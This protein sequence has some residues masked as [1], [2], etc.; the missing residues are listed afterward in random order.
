MSVHYREAVLQDEEDLFILA[1]RLATSYTLNRVDFS[2]AFQH[3]LANSNADIIVAE[4]ESKL[5]GY[6]LA[7]HHT[8]FY[9]NG[10]VSWVEELFVLEEYRRMNIGKKLMDIVEEKAL[11]RGSRLVAL[12]TRRAGDFYK[13][14]G[15]E[16]SA[17]Y[18]KKT[19]TDHRVDS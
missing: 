17:V 12:A 4:I 19:I 10:V 14:I 2:S 5:I 13:S 9:A 3:I 7:F 11:E 18:Y 8:T 15:Y 6:V 16:E 1:A